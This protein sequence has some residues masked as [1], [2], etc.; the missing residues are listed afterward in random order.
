MLLQGLSS[1]HQLL[2][3]QSFNDGN[4]RTTGQRIAPKGGAVIAGLQHRCS[5]SP[6]QTGTD[7]YAVAKSFGGSHHI[8][9]PVFVLIRKKP[10]GAAIAGMAF[11]KTT[12]PLVLVVQRQ[13]L[14][15]LSRYAL[16]TV[17]SVSFV[18]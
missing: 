7:G 13:Q 12:Q 4:P 3:Q 15:N 10:S 1:L 18:L 9:Q 8:G 6:R 11:I 2:L 17:L 14:F 16:Q 5:N